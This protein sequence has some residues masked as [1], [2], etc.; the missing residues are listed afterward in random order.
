MSSVLPTGVI[1]LLR[2]TSLRVDLDGGLGAPEFPS[3]DKEVVVGRCRDWRRAKDAFKLS[4]DVTA[5]SRPRLEVV[6]AGIGIIGSGMGDGEGVLERATDDL[7]GAR[8]REV[9]DAGGT[10]SSLM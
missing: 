2:R 8:S 3:F 7:A 9:F 1:G 5:P 6:E 10:F 4:C